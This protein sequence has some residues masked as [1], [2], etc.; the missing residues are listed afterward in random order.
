MNTVTNHSSPEQ[1]RRWTI[2]LPLIGSTD[3]MI[4]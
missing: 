4:E 1:R 3:E 2:S